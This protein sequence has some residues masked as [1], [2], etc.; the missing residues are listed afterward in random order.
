M[1]SSEADILR[2]E[3]RQLQELKASHEELQ[4]RHDSAQADLQARTQNCT[5]LE[6]AQA[7]LKHEVARATE[8]QQKASQQH[9]ELQTRTRQAQERAERL[10][11]QHAEV[12]RE[13]D[14]AVE[15]GNRLQKELSTETAAREQ[16]AQK[17][18]ETK[19]KVAQAEESE[20]AA[21]EAL[22]LATARRAELDCRASSARTEAESARA[23]LRQAK[24]RLSNTMKSSERLREAGNSFSTELRRRAALWE[25]SLSEGRFDGLREALEQHDAPTVETVTCRN[26]ATPIRTQ[27]RENQD[28]E[29]VAGDAEG[30]IGVANQ[31]GGA[32]A[33]L[34]VV[35][36][37]DMAAEAAA[38]AASALP[39]PAAVGREAAPA[40]ALLCP[41]SQ[42]PVADPRRDELMKQQDMEPAAT[43]LCLDEGSRS[44]SQ[45]QQPPLAQADLDEVQK[46]ADQEQDR[47]NRDG[48]LVESLNSVLLPKNLPAETLPP[49]ALS[50][51]ATP[52]GGMTSAPVGCSTAW[53]LE[54]LEDEVVS[55]DRSVKRQKTG[56]A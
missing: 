24:Q 23:A 53:S 32:V 4:R 12:Q 34:A 55:P 38:A 20:R 15:E 31:M 56:G 43:A 44:D 1:G 22:N 6:A 27:R 45:K 46:P 11:L 17:V 16:L 50:A 2:N 9:A 52:I 28:G 35:A 14:R 40:D 42:E 18:E 19:E 54:L 33:T 25:K 39:S 10:E 51:N 3:R 21:Q 41:N 7:Q 13:A 26:D 49:H 47:G 5:Q 29:G 8:A 48:L 30:N 36:A 37:P